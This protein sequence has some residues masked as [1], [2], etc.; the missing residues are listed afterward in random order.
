MFSCESKKIFRSVFK[1]SLRLMPIW[2]AFAWKPNGHSVVG[3][4]LFAVP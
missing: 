2:L 3:L 4:A 1:H